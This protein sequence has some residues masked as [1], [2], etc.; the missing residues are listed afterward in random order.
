MKIKNLLLFIA[1]V[2]MVNNLDA[3]GWF[4]TYSYGEHEFINDAKEVPGGGYIFISN[5]NNK[6][7]V[8]RVDS[9]GNSLWLNDEIDIENATFGGT[10]INT[11]DDGFALVCVTSDSSSNTPSRILLTKLDASGS[12]SWSSMLSFQ[13]SI[14]QSPYE[15]I[16]TPDGGYLIAC[17]VDGRMGLLKTNT[18]GELEWNTVYNGID[19]AVNN[20]FSFALDN[21]NYALTGRANPLGAGELDVVYMLQVDP[22]G[23]QVDFDSHPLAVVSVNDAVQ[24]DD[25]GVLLVGENSLYKL[26]SSGDL[27]WTNLNLLPDSTTDFV[28]AA[29]NQDGNI[30][31]TGPLF[32]IPVQFTLINQDGEVQWNNFTEMPIHIL[33][34]LRIII[35][36]SDGGYLLGGGAVDLGEP[37]DSINRQLMLIKVDSLGRLYTSKLQ[38]HVYIDENQNCQYDAGEQPVAGKVLK[39]VADQN[40]YGISDSLG[41]FSIPIDTGNFTLQLL[42]FANP[43]WEVCPDSLTAALSILSGDTITQDFGLSAI[44]ACPYLEVDLSA[45]HLRRCFESTYSVY[46]INNGTIPAINHY[47]E[48]SLDPF[49]E[50]VSS[51]IPLASQQGNTFTFNLDTIGVNESDYFQITVYV[52]CEAELGQTH[53]SEVHIYPDSLCLASPWTGPIINVEGYCNEDSI[54]FRIIN[55]GGAM[56]AL[57]PYFLIENDVVLSQGSF[58]LGSQQEEHFNIYANGST[59]RLEAS[60]V[61]GFPEA[62]GNTFASTSIEGCNGH[63]PGFISLFPEDDGA[64][65]LSIDCQEN[66]G[67]FDPNDKRGFPAGFGEE[68]FIPRN[69]DLEYHIRFQNTGTDTAF[70]VVIRDTLDA[71][72]NIGSLRLGASS[73][74]LEFELYGTGILKFT[75]NDILLPDSNVNEAGSHGFVKFRIAQTPDLPNG[76]VVKNSAG[77]YFD[78]NPP[79]ITNQTWHT[80][81]DPL[82]QVVA[83]QDVWGPDVKTVV[84][85]NPLTDETAIH[86][87][88]IE[89]SGGILRLFNSQGQ[90]VKTQVFQTNFI[91]FDAKQLPA[92]IYGFRLESAGR[93]ISTGKLVVQ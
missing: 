50:Y 67:A 11:S 60:Q 62:L 22:A 53:C 52:S 59:Y 23:N 49:L 72:L 4:R 28:A 27:E 93:L 75:F 46:Y 7:L 10:I 37:V 82:M 86:V 91:R 30:M 90:I 64:S 35:S 40:F 2:F 41:Q 70:T 12:I 84:R 68:H 26:G 20:I 25:G 38:G 85:P 19:Q 13:Y 17:K 61:E 1:I 92:G 80:I 74:P 21:G 29:K 89:L 81:G 3:Q 48:V 9:E 24:T 63:I 14:S 6:S 66:I 42:N 5:F 36:I 39:L 15:L 76:T 71:N 18:Q 73:H 87:E 77:I 69:T 8:Y 65:Y 79:V 56:N 45:F 34:V 58:Q 44:R 78:F 32:A 54:Q 51:T 31:L 33:K 83:I 55:Q 16:Q 47:V 43:Y 88:G 57:S